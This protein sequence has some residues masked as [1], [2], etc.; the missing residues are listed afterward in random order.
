MLRPL[1]RLDAGLVGAA[2][3]EFAFESCRGDHEQIPGW[4]SGGIR[5]R[6]GRPS[7]GEDQLAR[8]GGGAVVV[9]LEGQFTVEDVE[10]LV[11]GV[12]VQGRAGGAGGHRLLDDRDRAA[13]L[14]AAHQDLV[15]DALG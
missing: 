6:V 7:R 8:L 15:A 13:A 1:G 4:D 9:D 11:E 3:C 5:E 14:L 2:P 10:R 12:R